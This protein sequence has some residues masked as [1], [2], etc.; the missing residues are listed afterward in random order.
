MKPCLIN[1]PD[2]TVISPSPSASNAYLQFVILADSVASIDITPVTDPTM[3]VDNLPVVTSLSITIAGKVGSSAYSDSITLQGE[4][5]FSTINNQ[6]LIL[7]GQVGNGVAG[8]TVTV[9]SC[10][11][12]SV[13]VE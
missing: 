10:G 12:T 1:K 5:V 8:S 9:T 4:S 3:K 7:Q 6:S 2:L 11:Q 13:L